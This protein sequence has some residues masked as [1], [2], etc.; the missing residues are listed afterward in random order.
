MV[1]KKALKDVDNDTDE[2]QINELIGEIEFFNSYLFEAYYYED[3]D[4]FLLDKTNGKRTS[5]FYGFPNI[6][7]N[8]KHIITVYDIYGED[9]SG[10]EIYKINEDKI[11]FQFDFEFLN[12]GKNYKDFTFY[13]F[14]D[15]E[16]VI[17]VYPL[18]GEGIKEEDLIYLRFKIL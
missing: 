8:K 3:M 7:P 15:N 14:N 12:F 5:S 2:R 9:N 10:M 16:F 11:E 18:K 17:S 6:S 1:K 4:Y 13:W